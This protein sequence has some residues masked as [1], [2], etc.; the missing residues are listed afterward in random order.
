MNRLQELL[1]AHRHRLLAVA[2]LVLSTLF[3]LAL[4]I[5]RWVMTGHHAYGFFIWN[6]FLA[7]IPFW[8]ACVVYYGHLR[9]TRRNVLM[10]GLGVLWLLFF[11]NSPYIWTD[12]VH[13]LQ[14]RPGVAWWCDLVM[15][16]SFGW[17]GMLLGLVSLYLIQSVVHDRLGTGWGWMTVIAA[18]GLGSFG[19]ALG[20]FDRFNSWDLF[21]KPDELL[22]HLVGQFS[23]PLA[24]PLP[25]AIT[26]LF[27]AFL[28]LAYLTMIAL[29]SFERDAE[30]VCEAPAAHAE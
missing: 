16:L 25:F 6:L 10:A 27:F 5:V 7:W 30:R 9:G 12:L 21:F 8:I 18:L 22:L 24:R 15:A 28:S 2:T 20:R 23:H 29:M 11:P 14:T 13:L 17:N 26:A 3:S 4:V 1:I 19:I